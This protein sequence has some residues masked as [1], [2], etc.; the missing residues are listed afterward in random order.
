MYLRLNIDTCFNSEPPIPSEIIV[1]TIK[2]KTNMLKY[3]ILSIHLIKEC[4][5]KQIIYT[6]AWK[7]QA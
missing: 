6:S 1:I 4:Q 5:C 3:L 7:Y 2:I